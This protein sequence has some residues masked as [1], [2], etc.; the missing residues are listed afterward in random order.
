MNAVIK[1]IQ[2][3]RQECAADIWDPVIADA[4]QTASTVVCSDTNGRIGDTDVPRGLQSSGA[5]TTEPVVD[6]TRR[7]A[8]NNVIVYFEEDHEPT[9]SAECWLYSQR[10]R[11]WDQKYR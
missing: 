9:D 6:T 7:D 4:A 5:S 10:L 2:A 8:E 11:T 3:Q 1:Q